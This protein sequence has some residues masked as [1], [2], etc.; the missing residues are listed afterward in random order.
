MGKGK[1]IAGLVI[2]GVLLAACAA[3]V[4]WQHPSL[5][6]DQWSIDRA[7]CM[8]RANR[9][10]DKEL[11]RQDRLADS[12]RS[13]LEKDFRHFDATKRRDAFFAGCL[14]DKGYV[15]QTP[16]PGEN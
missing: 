12:R 9:L 1:T 7:T 15:K 2:A 14:R 6:S 13:S 5:R 8:A 4:R 16:R 10:I 3:P 11:G